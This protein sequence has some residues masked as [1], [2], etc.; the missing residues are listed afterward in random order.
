MRS[1]ET[2][3]LKD[4]DHYDQLDGIENRRKMRLH[5]Y[6]PKQMLEIKEK[7]GIEQCKR[8]LS[9]KA[10]AMQIQGVFHKGFYWQ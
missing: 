5:L 7:S 10:Y 6:P 1:A 8:F 3:N 4:E 2:A 9:M